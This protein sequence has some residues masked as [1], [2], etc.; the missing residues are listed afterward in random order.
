[1]NFYEQNYRH[2][3]K[4]IINNGYSKSGR[5]GGTRYLFGETLRI[6]LQGGLP[7]LTGRKMHLKGILAELACFIHGAE[8]LAEYKALGCNYWDANAANWEKNA[9][10]PQEKQSIGQ[11][12]GSLWR[13]F[14]AHTEFQSGS[15]VARD[16]LSTLLHELRVN[17]LSRRH[18]LAAW[19]PGAESCLPPCTVMAIFNS[20]GKYLHCHVTQRSADMCLGVPTDVVQY[21]ILTH[22]LAQYA[23]LLPGEL[24]FTFVD[25]HI[26]DAH[27]PALEEYLR[28]NIVRLPKLYLT[29]QYS[30]DPRDFMP[31][32]IR[33]EDYNPGPKIDFPFVA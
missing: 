1:M 12:V 5:N 25:A 7:L 3:L 19:H 33:I 24:M 18:V 16:Q 31:E 8:A 30:G 6:R 22:L 15:Y 13:D 29:E 26:Y 21:A 17:P 11:Y 32:H 10:K 4:K 27:R 20:D 28:T 23:G 2:L 9:G 14:K